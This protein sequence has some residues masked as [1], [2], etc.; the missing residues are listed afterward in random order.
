MLVNSLSPPPL[1]LEMLN[2]YF[3]FVSLNFDRLGGRLKINNVIMRGVNHQEISDFVEFTK[4]KEV[5]VRFI[6]WMPFDSNGWNDD[7]FFSY[8]E[9]KGKQRNLSCA[10]VV[11]C[12]LF[13][14]HNG[15]LLFY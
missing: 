4:E 10:G 9:M 7:T 1:L 8:E 12:C 13:E 2:A 3:Q 5:D 14:S 11:G 15:L 6:E